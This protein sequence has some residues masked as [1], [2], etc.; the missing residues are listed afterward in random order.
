M[1]NYVIGIDLAK[2]NSDNTFLSFRFM[3]T[4]LEEMKELWEIGEEYKLPEFNK[5]QL[6][7]H[8]DDRLI[9][10]S[11]YGNDNED[12]FMSMLVR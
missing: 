10:S 11:I 1:S 12:V 8:K 2:E 3:N 7:L 9:I 5:K 4:C 6:G